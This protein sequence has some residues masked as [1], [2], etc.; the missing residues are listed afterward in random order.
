[1]SVGARLRS[2][3]A[4]LHAVSSPVSG[5][6]VSLCGFSSCGELCSG[7]GE[8]CAWVGG[9]SCMPGGGPACSAGRLCAGKRI[10]SLGR[11]SC[12][13][14]G[15]A[16]ESVALQ[17]PQLWGLSRMG[18]QRNLGALGTA[19]VPWCYVHGLSP[20]CGESVVLWGIL[21]GRRDVC[22][23]WSES[24]GLEKMLGFGRIC[25]LWATCARERLCVMWGQW[26]GL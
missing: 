22:D 23:L 20:C 2:C 4:C 24:L 1:M 10:L 12:A 5:V 15:D 3:A 16:S 9:R 26:E 8:L 25:V 13:G 21:V 6:C 17:G 18:H 19:F 14:W 11:E 7:M